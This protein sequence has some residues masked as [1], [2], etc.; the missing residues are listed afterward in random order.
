M[1]ARGVLRAVLQQN[2]QWHLPNTAVFSRSM[3]PASPTWLRGTGAATTA[4]EKGNNG[5]LGRGEGLRMWG[6]RPKKAPAITTEY[7][8]NSRS[9]R[10]S[11]YSSD[12]GSRTEECSRLSG[13]CSSTRAG[14]PRT[15]VYVIAATTRPVLYARGVPLHR[16]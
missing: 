9:E 13:R 10:Q 4:P 3:R 1:S 15:L 6:T 7:T 14:K 12:A 11:R 16:R 8:W 5:R 2:M